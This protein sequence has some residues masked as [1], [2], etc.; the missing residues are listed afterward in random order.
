MRDVTVGR[1]ELDR[2]LESLTQIS[3]YRESGRAA[4]DE[5]EERLWA[6]AFLWINVGSALKQFC[7]LRGITQGASPF[8]DV[9]RMRDRLCYKPA[10]SVSARIVWQTVVDDADDLM[11]LLSD[12]R[13]ALDAAADQMR[14]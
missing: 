6:L 13:A 1:A 12:L 8:P 11:T 7:R 3:R 14:D 2:A 9:I 10:S 5:S 4:F